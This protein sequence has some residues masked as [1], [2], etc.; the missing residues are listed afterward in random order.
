MEGK[1][2]QAYEAPE[3]EIIYLDNEDIITDSTGGDVGDIVPSELNEF[4]D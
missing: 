2:K 3:M 1:A 4:W